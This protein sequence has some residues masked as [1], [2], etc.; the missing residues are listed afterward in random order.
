MGQL[1]AGHLVKEAG[2]LGWTEVG[3][4]EA[5]LI[6]RCA[7]GEQSACAELVA[8]H[9]RMVYQL[10][11]YLLGDRDEALDLS[12]EVFLRVFR[13]LPS[14]RGQ[15]ALKTWIYRI[16][17]NQARNRQRWWRRRRRNDQVQLEYH[18][19]EHGELRQPTDG[20][21][22]DRALARKELARKLWSA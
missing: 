20:D 2:A 17:I 16:A 5:A 6:Q 18:V 21:S 1:V 13:T 12:Q 10:A 11:F 19:L 15:S 8:S 3:T 9:E 14:F 4:A 7:A 22:P